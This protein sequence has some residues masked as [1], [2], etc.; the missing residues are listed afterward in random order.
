METACDDLRG[1]LEHLDQD[2]YLAASSLC[3]WLPNV[4]ATTDPR[5][6]AQLLRRA[7]LDTV[8]LLRP[9]HPLPFGSREARSY[10][11]LSLR[12][13]EGMASIEIAEELG[14]SERQVYRDLR[15]ALAQVVQL[16]HPPSVVAASP[17]GEPEDEVLQ[18]EMQRVVM[19][20]RGL[21]PAQMIAATVTS[22]EPLARRFGAV[23]QYDPSPDLPMVSADEGLLRQILA[24]ALSLG[25]QSA[26]GGNLHIRARE[27]EDRVV[28]TLDFPTSGGEL[29]ETLLGSLRVLAEVQ[30]LGL[31]VKSVAG[32]A[33]IGLTVGIARPETVLVVEDNEG[34]IELYRRY[35]AQA[36]GWLIS[37]ATDPR[38]AVDIARRT[39]PAVILLD[40]MM[41]RQDGWS[42]L[43]TLR[44]HPDTKDIPVIV[45]SVF[46]DPELA[47]AL[48]ADAYLRKPVSRVQLLTTLRSAV[49]GR[50]RPV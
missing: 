7:L 18:D 14:V 44:A 3:I 47:T 12:Y 29:N 1:A 50:S 49:D 25:I 31:I 41:P 38:V 39:H 23:V 37:G 22:L 19:H 40:I 43:Q 28:V 11:V 46:A 33:G 10:E 24:Q 42:V 17:T 30:H 5:A 36:D 48:G 35:L 45:C 34:A 21:D 16:M 2:S 32:S 13:V 8:E 6:R 27:E 15:Q 4:A 9:A 26:A 20:P